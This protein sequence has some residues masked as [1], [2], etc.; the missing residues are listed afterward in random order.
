[1]GLGELPAKTVGARVRPIQVPRC[2]FCVLMAMCVWACGRRR[3]VAQKGKQPRI[4]SLLNFI[5]SPSSPWSIA[6]RML[7]NLRKS[8]GGCALSRFETG[9]TRRSGL[10]VPFVRFG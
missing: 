2:I 4:A 9:C 10:L 7:I 5:R 6:K 1:V 3:S 8:K